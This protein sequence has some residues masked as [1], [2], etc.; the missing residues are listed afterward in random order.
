MSAFTRPGS[1]HVH[2]KLSHKEYIDPFAVPY[3]GT[4]AATKTHSRKFT[5]KAPRDV[6]GQ[7]SQNDDENA[8]AADT[9]DAD[10]AAATSSSPARRRAHK[11][12]RPPPLPRKHKR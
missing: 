12:R 3:T 9:A 6:H 10:A 5:A 8:A 2:T 1:R 4:N 11:P 7:L